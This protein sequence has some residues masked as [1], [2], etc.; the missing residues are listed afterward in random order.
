MH[1][2]YALLCYWQSSRRTTH[3]SIAA[4]LC[5]G[6]SPT[7]CIIR[8]PDHSVW[9]VRLFGMERMS[10][11]HKIQWRRLFE[12]MFLASISMLSTFH[13]SYFIHISL[14]MH[15]DVQ[16]DADFCVL[17]D[18]HWRRIRSLTLSTKPYRHAVRQHDPNRSAHTTSKH[19]NLHLFSS[20]RNCSL[21]NRHSPHTKRIHID[22]CT[23]TLDICLGF[24]QSNKLSLA[25]FSYKVS[26]FSCVCPYPRT[27]ICLIDLLSL[28]SGWVSNVDKC[29][30]KNKTNFGVIKSN[31]F[32]L[33][34]ELRT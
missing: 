22:M 23:C 7:K 4:G 14:R 19:D 29:F 25:I 26:A 15:R 32:D 33:I 30:K 1:I 21:Q 10:L 24:V 13:L 16:N 3:I 27:E 12:E 6:N 18:N 5:L 17:E 28:Q 34:V 20:S 2:F 9:S 11:P 31:L 8:S